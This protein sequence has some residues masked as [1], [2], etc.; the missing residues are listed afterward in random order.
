MNYIQVPNSDRRLYPGSVVT[1]S[2]FPRTQW[3]LNIGWYAFEGKQYNGWYLCSI[4]AETILPVNES[5]LKHITILSD[6]RDDCNCPP[7]CDSNVHPPR[8][9]YDCEPHHHHH[10][11][12]DDCGCPPRPHPPI[13]G[14]KPEPPKSRVHSPERYYG[15]INYI[16]GQLVY[17]VEGSLYQAT[18]NFRSSWKL[19]TLDEN[20]QADV[21]AGYLIA[22]P[23]NIKITEINDEIDGITEEIDTNKVKKYLLSFQAVFGTDTPTNDEAKHYLDTIGVKPSTSI[24]FK[25]TDRNSTTFGHVYTFYETVQGRLVLFDETVDTHIDYTEILNSKVDKKFLSD[26]GTVTKDFEITKSKRVDGLRIRKTS[27]SLET[28]EVTES[29]DTP[30]YEE[31]GIASTESVTDIDDK[32]NDKVNTNDFN[33]AL[34][35]KVDVNVAGVDSEGNPNRIIEDC[36]IS[37]AEDGGIILNKSNLSFKDSS[38]IETSDIVGLSAMGAVSEDEF[39]QAITYEDFD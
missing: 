5:D 3:V 16:Q 25:N 7:H 36:S 32:L 15:G 28:G 34:E 2:R 37:A 35:S 29:N 24:Y 33:Q 22:I 11:Y 14:P 38:V 17:L 23:N 6:G 39:K 18:V 4:P 8:P 13:P 30:T 20:L 19:P 21:N 31:L 1:I 12:P 26:I 10:P 27:V 9:P